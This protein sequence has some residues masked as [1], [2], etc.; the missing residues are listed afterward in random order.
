VAR[1]AAGAVA[2]APGSG[3]AYMFVG[4]G[5][6]RPQLGIE[7]TSANVRIYWALPATG[8]VLDELG[9]LDN[10]SRTGWSQVT[11]PYQT[12]TTQ[13]SITLPMPSS[14]L[15]FRLRKE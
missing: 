4:I 7:K 6:L 2:G 14:T 13:I 12:N 1:R 3:A 8:F 5:S 15:F 10:S 11:F 9:A